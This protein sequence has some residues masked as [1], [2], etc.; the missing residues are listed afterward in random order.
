MKLNWAT[1]KMA[2]V[3]AFSACAGAAN[4][5]VNVL[6]NGGFETG[7]ASWTTSGFTLQGYDYGIDQA[8]HSGSN[9]F[10]GGAIGGLGFL[11]QSFASVAGQM[12]GIDL[13]LSSDGFLPNQFQVLVNGQTLL[14]REDILIQPYGLLHTSFVATGAMTQLQ[15]AF[16]NDSGSLHLDDVNVAAIPEPTTTALMAAGL[17]A[18]AF[19]RRRRAA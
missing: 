8:A 11:S 17:G 1:V 5:Q 14:N 2:G 13:W 4:A 15:F 12:Y 10:Y 9:A 16:R 19:L 18:L 6:V 7:L 3:L